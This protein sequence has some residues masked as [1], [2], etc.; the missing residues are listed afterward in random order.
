MSFKL[1]IDNRERVLI[2]YFEK[3]CF[4][5][6]DVADI[7]IKK[8]DDILV[9]I[10]RKTIDDLKAS[11]IDGRLK[12]QKLRLLNLGIKPSNIIY[13]IEGNIL[14]NTSIKGGSNTL[15]GSLV[16]TMLRD[17]ILVYKSSSLK[18]TSMFIKKIYNNCQKKYD[19]F[20]CKNNN[21]DNIDYC[22]TIKI[23]KKDNYTP[24]VWYK[25]MLLSIPQVSVRI[26]DCIVKEYTSLN[27]L[28][29]NLIDENSLKELKF[30][31]STGKTRR[32]GPALSKKIYNYFKN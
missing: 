14:K 24:Q 25:H 29:N 5:N 15:I 16:N 3:E 17:G 7:I 1:F 4:C 22:S 19:E 26:A 27:S 9:A 31:T 21:K 12:E 32:I 30:E 6:L 11:I 23:R 10:E 2:N 13:L 18:E 28:F 8:D 20:F